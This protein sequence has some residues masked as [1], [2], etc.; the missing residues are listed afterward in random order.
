[1][2]PTYVLLGRLIER[3]S[4]KPFIEYIQEKIF[5]PAG[6][7]QTYYNGKEKNKCHAYEYERDR[8]EGQ[9]EIDQKVH[10]IGM[11]MTMEKKH[12]L[13]QDLMEVYSQLQEILLNGN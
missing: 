9:V 2:N 3:I 1:M 6:M 8:G 4:K 10:I 7:T 12:F 11:N 13:A 5:D